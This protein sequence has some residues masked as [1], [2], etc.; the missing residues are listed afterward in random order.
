MKKIALFAIA[1]I[2]VIVSFLFIVRNNFFGATDCATA[3]KIAIAMQ[4]QTKSEWLF[5]QD[6]HTWH[7]KYFLSHVRPATRKEYEDWFCRYIQEQKKIG[8]RFK[9]FV[10]I[11]K[12]SATMVRLL[13][14]FTEQKEILEKEEG[15]PADYWKYYNYTLKGWYIATEDFVMPAS[16]DKMQRRKHFDASDYGEVQTKLYVIVPNGIN[17]SYKGL[18]DNQLFFEEDYRV[19]GNDTYGRYA[20]PPVIPVYANLFKR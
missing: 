9:N 16:I 4:D 2:A 20:D 1:G 18:G 6:P 19:V 8:N 12:Q 3:E 13:G 7:Q 10:K 14:N 15:R 5:D 17:V 11:S